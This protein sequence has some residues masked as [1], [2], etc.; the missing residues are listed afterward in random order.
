M[1]KIKLSIL[2]F[3][4]F[5]LTANVVNAQSECIGEIRLFTYNFIPLGWVECNG[6]TLQV[7][8][9]SS[10]F[11]VIGNS[12]GGNGFS[13]F[14]VPDLRGRVPIMPGNIAGLSVTIAETGG[15]ETEA[16]TVA[17]LP[18]HSHSTVG[19]ARLA[20][21]NSSAQAVSPGIF[22]VNEER[23]N[24][25]NTTSNAV[26]GT[27]NVNVSPSG[28]GSPRNNLQPYIALVWCICVD[29]LWP[30]RN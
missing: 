17:Q 7:S 12:Y 24:E 23:G 14:C 22:A 13:T 21:S 16:M 1:K 10:L 15:T 5:V 28:N 30:E 29:G 18:S 4:A 26:S 19:V 27:M 6:Q 25:F 11:A 9:Y 3:L 20:C 8:E 2:S